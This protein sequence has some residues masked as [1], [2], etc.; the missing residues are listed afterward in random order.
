M[1][2]GDPLL[3][4]HHVGV[5][6][7]TVTYNSECVTCEGSIGDRSELPWY[8]GA[9]RIHLS[10]LVRGAARGEGNPLIRCSVGVSGCTAE[11]LLPRHST[12]PEVQR[13]PLLWTSYCLLRRG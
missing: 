8:R 9:R 5:S 11:L 3:A 7:A 6:L 10:V 4:R 1:G 13:T 12:A 2:Q